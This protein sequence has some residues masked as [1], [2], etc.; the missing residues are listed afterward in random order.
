MH[1]GHDV[2]QTVASMEFVLN[3]S[4]SSEHGHKVLRLDGNLLTRAVEAAGAGAADYVD[5]DGRLNHLRRLMMEVA[6]EAWY[7]SLK[8]CCRPGRDGNCR[9]L[10][11]KS[12]WILKS[13]IIALSFESLF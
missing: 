13:K 12:R 9:S 11:S 2:A 10:P 7:L 3:R 5:Y 1:V 6:E 8:Y 4:P